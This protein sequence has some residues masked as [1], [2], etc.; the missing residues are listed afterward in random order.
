M[1]AA[2]DPED[3]YEWYLQQVDLLESM[4]RTEAPTRDLHC[5]EL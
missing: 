5:T 3:T 1:T 4:G 2:V